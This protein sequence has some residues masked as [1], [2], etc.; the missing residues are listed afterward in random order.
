VVD[1]LPP[2]TLVRLHREDDGYR[3]LPEDQRQGQ[4]PDQPGNRS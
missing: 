4:P 1:D 3:L 2:G